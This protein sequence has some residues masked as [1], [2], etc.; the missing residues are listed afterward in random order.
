[1]LLSQR[2]A[3]QHLFVLRPSFEHT[4]LGYTSSS[5]LQKH[6]S[7]ILDVVVSGPLNGHIGCVLSALPQFPSA[8][9]WHLPDSSMGGKGTEERIL[10]GNGKGHM[11]V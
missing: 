7:I 9:D 10:Y 6:P 1:M 2:R 4:R 3:P 8:E 11:I 5:K